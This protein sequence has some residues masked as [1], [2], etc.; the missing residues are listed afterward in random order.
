MSVDEKLAAP[1]IIRTRIG[2]MTYLAPMEALT[3]EEPLLEFNS[4]SEECLQS[5]EIQI[6]VDLARVPLLA[7][8]AMEALLAFQRRLVKLGG[9]LKVTNVNPTI[10]EIFRIT[11]FK[12]FISII[13]PAGSFSTPHQPEHKQPT[14]QKLGDILIEQGLL[15]SE[16]I[17]DAITLQKKTGKRIGQ[18]LI[19]KGWVTEQQTLEALAEQ[20]SLPYVKLKPGL[21][22]PALTS[23]LEKHT[24]KRLRVLPL[25]KVFGLL[26]LAT[27]DPQAAPNIKE[28]EEFTG[29]QV[30][31]VLAGREDILKSIASSTPENPHTEVLLNDLEDDFE[32][33]ATHEIQDYSLIDEMAAE[34]PVINL[35]NSLI[36]RA[37]HDQASD[38]HL[39]P[40][41]TTSRI[42][43]RIDGLLY[44]VMTPK[45]EMHPAL[46]S[47][48]KVMANL[49]IA[50]HRLPQ[51]GRIQ[52]HTQGRAVDLRFSSLPTLYGE[53]IVLRVLDKNQAIL[54]IDK[55]GLTKNN[56]VS[57]KHL[58]SRNHGL[59][60]V[61]GPTG[62]GKTT[63]LYAVINYLNSIE[64]HIVTIEDPV[65]YQMEIINQNEV[66]AHIGLAAIICQLFLRPGFARGRA[67][68]RAI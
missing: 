51:D 1:R 48:L 18:I 35:I 8:T 62:S 58:A 26:F 34:S 65:E 30:R 42:R 24:L 41:R 28:V 12:D 22:D 56:V 59:I 32:V 38:I 3:S 63:T 61:T 49:D 25:F 21:F 40:S 50:E 37:V 33:I 5:Q 17:N 29:C 11:D 2:V 43:F 9:W 19:D 20:L 6:V 10:R 14:N 64:K 36:Q 52:V 16:R 60:L 39:E 53:K 46:V 47:R 13:D 45:I 68:I 23:L 7:S 67:K 55:L 15:T 57:L 44:E 66:K 4:A 31:P 54:D 27:A